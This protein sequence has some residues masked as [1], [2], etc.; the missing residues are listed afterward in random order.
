MNFDANFTN[1]E[2]RLFEETQIL[3]ADDRLFF[4]ETVDPRNREIAIISSL[5]I[6]F[7]CASIVIGNLFFNEFTEWFFIPVGI[8]FLSVGCAAR[9][10]FTKIT[11]KRRQR[12][13]KIIEMNLCDKSLIYYR[14]KLFYKYFNTKTRFSYILEFFLVVSAGQTFSWFAK[15]YYDHDVSVVI[16]SLLVAMYL[17][18][19]NEIKLLFISSDE[20]QLNRIIGLISKEQKSQQKELCE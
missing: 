4:A 11:K 3:L 7:G 17:N 13:D 16:W 10:S 18:Y 20:N 6:F 14:Q 9:N 15:T 2:I 8:V 12:L 19:I 1:D 5:Y